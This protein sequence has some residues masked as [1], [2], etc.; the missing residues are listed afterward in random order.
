MGDFAFLLLSALAVLA[1]AADDRSD[2]DADADA[3]ADSDNADSAHDTV[4][5]EAYAESGGQARLR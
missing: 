1:A 4:A 5:I 2:A 3:D